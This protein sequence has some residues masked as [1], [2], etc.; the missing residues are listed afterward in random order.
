MNGKRIDRNIGI[1]LLRI[2]AM[3]FII[4]QH[5]I[6]SLETFEFVFKENLNDNILLG[7][8]TNNIEIIMLNLLRQLGMLGN[9]IFF[10]CSCWFCVE[11]KQKNGIYKSFKILFQTWM[12]SIVILICY[13]IIDFKVISIKSIIKSVFPTLFCNNW[14]VTCYI[15]FLLIYPL[16]NIVI[17]S[18][19]QKSHL[20][21]V[22]LTSGLWIVGDYFNKNL[23]F[24]SFV[25]T[26]IAIYILISYL[27]IYCKDK[28]NEKKIGIILAIIGWS[29]YFLQLLITNYAGVHFSDYCSIN[30]LKWNVLPNPFYLMIAIGSIIIF[31]SLRFKLNFIN[32]FAKLTLYIYLIHENYLFR[33]YTRPYIW[34]WIY[35]NLGFSNLFF[36]ILAFSILLMIISAILGMI[37]E[38]LCNKKINC[39]IQK[40]FSIIQEYYLKIERVLIN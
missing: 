36:E 22:I 40:C 17:S 38:M 12:I 34:R 19:N 33:T 11:R 9:V 31:S 35:V 32:E 26:W 39:F 1:D 5:V 4:I 20:K 21:L 24:S 28:I 30:I 27:K 13:L 14:Y 2:I 16:V 7:V 8:A 10:V 15:I 25:L 6:Q 29:G 37:F 3:L 23:F 18:I